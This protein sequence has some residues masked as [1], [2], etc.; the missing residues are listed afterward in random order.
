MAVRTIKLRPIEINLIVSWKLDMNDEAEVKHMKEANWIRAWTWWRCRFY[1]TPRFKFRKKV[2]ESGYRLSIRFL[3]FGLDIETV[4]VLARLWLARYKYEGK[5]EKRRYDIKLEDGTIVPSCYPN[6]DTFS[7]INGI[8]YPGYQ[9]T[10]IRKWKS[11]L[12]K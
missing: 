2:F 4:P 6:A 10:H 9:V 3:C 1:W 12:E 11:R 5:Y 8:E 7:D